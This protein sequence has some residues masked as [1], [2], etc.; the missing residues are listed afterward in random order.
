MDRDAFY[1]MIIQASYIKNFQCDGKICDCR[2]CREWAIPLDDDSREKFLTLK[3][4]ER[5]KI[6]QNIDK[7]SSTLKLSQDLRCSF[8]DA[9][10][11]C[12]IQKKHGEDFLPAI[13]QSYPRMTFKLGENFFL[14]SMTLTCPVAAQL[15]LLSPDPINFVEVQEINSRLIIDFRKYLTHSPHEFFQTQMSAIKI[16]Q[17][18]NFSVNERLKNLCEFFF[19]KKF[20]P[21]KFNLEKH[22]ETLI[23]IFDEMYAANLNDAQKKI[24]HRNFSQTGEK[25]LSDIHSTFR[26]ILENYLV[27]EFFMRC[28]PCA[29]SG[30]DWQNCKIFVASFRILEFS[31]VLTLLSKKSITVFELLDLICAVS[32]KLDHNKFGMDAI[33][34]FAEKND[35]ENFFAQMLK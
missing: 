33:K 30:D 22:F 12:K 17:E 1:Q 8:L 28:Y 34:H 16:L 7:T 20:P 35:A 31:T 3:T 5:E 24:L 15:I 9:D 2:C 23:E 19:Q 4:S 14:Q 21:F 29:F 10:G 18:K 26:Q 13:C 25:I 32:D 6:F 27:N 11:L